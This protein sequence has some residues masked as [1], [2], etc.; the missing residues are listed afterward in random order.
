MNTRILLGQKKISL[1]VAMAFALVPLAVFAQ[2]LVPCGGSG[3][4]ACD[5][6]HFIQLIQNVIN[7]LIK[8]VAMPLAAILFAWAGIMMFTAGGNE[9]KTT[10][11]K[12]IFWWVLVG[13]I[14][15]LSAWLIVSAITSALLKPEY[16][17]LG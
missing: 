2:G 8:D 4:P 10:Q 15:A 13:L 9:Q 7:F 16:S 17:L 12:E 1:L 14:V 3:Q 6:A 5:F 11:A